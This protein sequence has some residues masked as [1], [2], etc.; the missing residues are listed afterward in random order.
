MRDK[1][2]PAVQQSEA[3]MGAYVTHYPTQEA[4]FASVASS[5]A[6]PRGA[7]IGQGPKSKGMEEALSLAPIS[8]STLPAVTAHSAA[9]IESMMLL[10]DDQG[11]RRPSSR[12][13]RIFCLFT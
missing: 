7:R 12:A 13:G 8:K 5:A 4:A 9:T 10:D 1:H 6:G 11:N 3:G 2:R